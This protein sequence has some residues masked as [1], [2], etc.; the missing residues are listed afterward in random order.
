MSGMKEVLIIGNYGAGN[1]GDEAILESLLELCDQHRIRANVVSA[2]PEATREAHRVP[3]T[4]PLAA[5]LRS[6]LQFNSQQTKKY[7]TETDA[8]ILGGG[9]LFTNET[10]QA[11]IIWARQAYQAMHNKKPLYCVG[12]SV[13]PLGSA[14]SRAITGFVFRYAE[15][16]I[17]R[18][19]ESAELLKDLGVEKDKI[20][21]AGDL[22]L[23]LPP[24]Q[25][26][27]N[28]KRKRMLIS[29]RSWHG[30][31]SQAIEALIKVLP[32]LTE[33]VALLPMGD[34]DE[35]ILAQVAHD[36]D[37]DAEII[38]PQTPQEVMAEIARAN[39]V[40]GMRLHS[41]ILATAQGIPCVGI[42]YSDKVTN[43]CKQICASC[44]DLPYI[45]SDALTKSIS[46][47]K[48]NL[49]KIHQ[50]QKDTEEKISR[51]LQKI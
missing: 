12:Q 4:L 45:T 22:A 11:P 40:I 32:T 20:E 48:I 25:T 50:I 38:H 16:T 43:F 6:F 2:N 13:G 42:S 17:L 41:L 46:Q 34:D 15:H 21:V 3:T 7:F 9:G 26:K 18:D 47:A 33:E 35:E 1:L 39:L 51:L 14:W 19:Q 31:H 27:P 23:L 44:I 28:P 29:L 36:I 8:I 30:L 24:S 49:P 5:G 37:L 10:F